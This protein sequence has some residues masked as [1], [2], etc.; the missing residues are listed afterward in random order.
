MILCELKIVYTYMC[1]MK[2][3]RNAKNT[4]FMIAINT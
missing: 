1:M 3:R 2:N 4:L